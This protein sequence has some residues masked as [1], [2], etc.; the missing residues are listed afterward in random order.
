MRRGEQLL[1]AA[2]AL[3]MIAPGL[4]ATLLGLVLASPALLRQLHAWRKQRAGL[5]VG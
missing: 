4:T 3:L 1:C 5:A 2:A